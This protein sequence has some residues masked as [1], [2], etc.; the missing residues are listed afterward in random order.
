MD[1]DSSALK[2]WGALLFVT[3]SEPKAWVSCLYE[4]TEF[5]FKPLN[6][7]IATDPIAHQRFIFGVNYHPLVELA[8]M[9][10]GV[11]IA[12]VNGE[13]W[14]LESPRECGPFNTACEW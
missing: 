10:H 4:S 12:V 14:L 8:Y 7:F 9:L 11:C 2:G 5:A 13:G 3:K 1:S 6:H